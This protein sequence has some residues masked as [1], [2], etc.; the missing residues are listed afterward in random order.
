MGGVR[1]RK[2]EVGKWC[3]YHNLKKKDLLWKALEENQR[4]M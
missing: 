2:G 1:G 4:E 3:N